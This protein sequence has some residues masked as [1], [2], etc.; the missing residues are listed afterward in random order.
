MMTA[1]EGQDCQL[2]TGAEIMRPATQAGAGGGPGRRRRGGPH[3][4]V[5]G[6]MKNAEGM[7]AAAVS[8]SRPT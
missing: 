2:R 3:R 8:Y 7:E 6:R 5:E 1:E 4:N